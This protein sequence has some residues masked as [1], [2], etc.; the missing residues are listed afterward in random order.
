MIHRCSRKNSSPIPVCARKAGNVRSNAF[1]LRGMVHGAIVAV[2]KERPSFN[3]VFSDILPDAYNNL[4]TK[5]QRAGEDHHRCNRRCNGLTRQEK[6]E[7]KGDQGNREC[8]ETH[9]PAMFQGIRKQRR[10]GM[11]SQIK[12]EDHHPAS[13]KV[14][15]EKNEQI[16]HDSLRLECVAVRACVCAC[17]TC[18]GVALPDT[19]SCTLPVGTVRM[20]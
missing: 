8:D 10:C 3:P 1:S 18:G 15:A 19:P 13:Q 17:M 12:Q 6:R 2:C 5:H 4:S 7:W 20:C 9:T 16:S 14:K 11:G